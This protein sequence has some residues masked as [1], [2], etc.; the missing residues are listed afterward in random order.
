MLA[1]APRGCMLSFSHPHFLVSA[2][3][4]KHSV[5]RCSGGVGTMWKDHAEHF[6]ASAIS[7]EK[8]LDGPCTMSPAIMSSRHLCFAYFAGNDG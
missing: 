2:I 8:A 4:S 5:V 7:L 3:I 1:S 6:L